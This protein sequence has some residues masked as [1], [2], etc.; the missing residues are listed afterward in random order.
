MKGIDHRLGNDFHNEKYEDG[1]R[2]KTRAVPI[3][4]PEIGEKDRGFVLESVWWS[5]YSRGYQD[6]R[7]LNHRHNRND[8]RGNHL[9]IDQIPAKHIKLH[10]SE[11]IRKLVPA[12]SG[13]RLSAETLRDRWVDGY[14]E[15]VLAVMSIHNPLMMMQSP[16]GD[17]DQQGE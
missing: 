7:V 4:W 1:G 2:T 5:G 11:A 6:S 16:E 14:H 3:T 10:C 8:G 15:G 9:L 12:I 17:P 13:A